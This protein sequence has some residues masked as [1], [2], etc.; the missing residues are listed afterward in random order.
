M[1]QYQYTCKI[2]LIIYAS[3]S[4]HMQDISYNICFNIITHARYII[5]HL[6][7]VAV[8]IHMQDISYNICFNIITHARYILLH[9]MYVAISIHMQDISYNICFNIITYARYIICHLM[10]VAIS[11]HVQDI[12]IIFR[13]MYLYNTN[14]LLFCTD[15]Y[16]PEVDNADRACDFE[17][18]ITNSQYC[19]Y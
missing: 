18:S 9:L 17:V 11:I 5:C 13:L 16:K 4:S 19:M 6:M 7:Y 15:K 1:L 14:C 8:S 2:Y 3:I 12:S 10:Y